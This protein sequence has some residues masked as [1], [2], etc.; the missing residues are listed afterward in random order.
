MEA[1]ID[2]GDDDRENDVTEDACKPLY[3]RMAALKKELS[4]HLDD[5]RRGEIIREGFRIVLAGPPNAG[6][7]LFLNNLSENSTFVLFIPAH[8][9]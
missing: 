9:T 4:D 3:P 8:N 1:V 2:F 7:P 5:G 6:T